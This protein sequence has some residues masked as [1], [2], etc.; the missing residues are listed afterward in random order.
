M[1]IVGVE[2]GLIVQCSMLG[3]TTLKGS[4]KEVPIA[5]PVFKYYEPHEGEINTVRFSPNRQDMFLSTASDSEIRIYIIGQDAPARVIFLEKL[6]NQI[7]WVPYQEKLVIG[8]GEKGIIEIFHL[9][10]GRS[11]P[12]VTSEKVVPTNLLQMDVNKQRCATVA[13]GNDKGEVQIWNVP[14][15]P[16]ALQ[17]VQ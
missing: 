11:I 14:W 3:T 5:D 1:F 8:C 15:G 10:S 16:F 9:I 6:L 2:G 13:I 17:K 4:T 12:N 7:C